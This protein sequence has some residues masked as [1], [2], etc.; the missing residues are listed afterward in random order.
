M[1][2]NK[3]LPPESEMSTIKSHGTAWAD[4]APRR[5]LSAT[6]RRVVG[7]LA[8]LHADLAPADF[9]PLGLAFF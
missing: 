5:F 6:G 2:Q 3:P 8:H 1:E 4:G 9:L 7:S